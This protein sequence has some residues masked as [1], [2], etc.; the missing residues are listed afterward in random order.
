MKSCIAV[1]IGGTKMLIAEVLED[2]TIV[3]CLRYATGQKS[4][5]ELVEIL[6][7]GILEYEN[8]IGWK[9]GKRPEQ[10]G[11]GINSIIDP[12]AGLWKGYSPADTEIPLVEC[13][14][15]EFN[16]R[17]YID[18][19][20]KC[21]VI[22]ENH[23]GAGKGSKDMV[24]INVGTGLAA[25]AITSGKVI[26]GSD[27]WAGEI[28]FMN[29]TEGQGDHVELRASGMGIRHQARLLA[30]QYPDSLLTESIER[31]VTGQEAMAAAEKGDALAIRILDT[32]YTMIGLMISNITCVL[33][34]EIVVL[35]GGLITD[36]SIVEKIRAKVLPKAASHLEKGVVQTKL[37]T[38]YA[39]LMGAAAIGLGYQQEH[40]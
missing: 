2:G 10:M 34:P 22:A 24:Y 38:D 13:M 31:G 36:E 35:G 25:G 14:E 7:Q 1:D 28:G 11:V 18:N 23:F 21:T 8:T 27:C 29:F 19:D 26:R 33:S 39:G 30:D 9:E 17:C 4:K 6:K 5:E 3:N 12:V 20:V 37:D 15:R 16:V 40:F 32:L